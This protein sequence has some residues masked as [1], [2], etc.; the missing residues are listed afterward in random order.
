MPQAERYEPT[1]E[2]HVFDGGEDDD[3]PEEEGSRLALLLV[4][5]LFVL[6]AFGGV[7]YLAYNQ[8][9]KQGRDEA[10]RPVVQ[11]TQLP[12]KLAAAPG[13][14]SVAPEANAPSDDDLANEDSAP[15]PPTAIPWAPKS[16]PQVHALTRNVTPKPTPAAP[17]PPPHAVAQNVTQKSTPAVVAPQPTRAT[18]S[19]AT[20]A[21]AAAK[22]VVK[23]TPPSK[24]LTRTA[25]TTPAPTATPK[26]AA[27]SP[28]IIAPVVSSAAQTKLPP[29]AAPKQQVATTTTAGPPPPTTTTG[30][31]A[32]SEPA[33][34][35]A[36][37]PGMTA[38]AKS[39]GGFVL[40]IGAYKS[41]AEAMAS[42]H[43]YKSAHAAAATYQPDIRQVQ[44][45]GKGT[46]YRLRI[47]S[48]TSPADAGT[49]CDKL[50]ASGGSCFPAKR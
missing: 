28:K 32:T 30:A 23:T 29:V 50:K 36:A 13:P 24:P 31:S 35:S 41:E 43:T 4:L 40:Q 5:A 45:P 1:G 48:F 10:P 49:L 16:A 27:H 15:P 42:W 34:T 14:K 38:P 8:G 18:S 46:W 25:T 17:A 22:T 37:A 2:L 19:P 47:G 20:G 12:Q 11:S 26:E 44:L 9:V 7:V 6:G 21:P 33:S 39:A 3:A